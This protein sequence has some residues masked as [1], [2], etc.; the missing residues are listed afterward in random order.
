M[1]REQ[2]VLAITGNGDVLVS[3]LYRGE[4]LFES[5]DVKVLK[6]KL[7]VEEALKSEYLYQARTIVIDENVFKSIGDTIKS[8][9]STLISQKRVKVVIWKGGAGEVPYLQGEIPE[10][11]RVAKKIFSEIRDIIRNVP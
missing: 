6:Q 7:S 10:A 11:L 9:L 2:R 1:K 3:V 4:L 5:L 8:L